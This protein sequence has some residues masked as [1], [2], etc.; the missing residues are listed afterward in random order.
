MRSWGVL[1]LLLVPCVGCPSDDTFICGDDSQCISGEAVG[2]CEL[3]GHCSFFDPDCPSERRYGQLGPTTLAGSCVPADDS[4]STGA[5]GSNTASTSTSTTQDATSS[6]LPSTTSGDSS[7]GDGG[8]SGPMADASTTSEVMGECKIDEFDD[9]EL[10]EEWF[11]Y[12]D[13]NVELVDGQVVITVFNQSVLEGIGTYSVLDFASAS[14]TAE[15]AQRPASDFHQQAFGLQTSTEDRYVFVVGQSQ[16]D[17]RH[18]PD[19]ESSSS[20][21]VTTISLRPGA[22]P[23]LQF[24]NRDGLLEFRYAV[25]ADPFVT[26]GS[27]EHSMDPSGWRVDL[28]GLAWAPLTDPVQV[29]FESFTMCELR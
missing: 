1:G 3:N 18:F 17:V 25:G 22:S 10:S 21:V 20:D 28:T 24:L 14:A 8:S 13:E 5:L 26:A 4:T 12:F 29:S 7:S 11:T 27:V 23:S 15:I 2:Q 9:P 16:V 6:P 19:L